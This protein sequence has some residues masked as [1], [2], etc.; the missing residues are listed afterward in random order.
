MLVVA[1]ANE[2][3]AAYGSDWPNEA[4]GLAVDLSEPYAVA[5]AFVN[6]TVDA[7]RI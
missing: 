5:N 7:G 3:V 1:L 6:A 2:F 4:G